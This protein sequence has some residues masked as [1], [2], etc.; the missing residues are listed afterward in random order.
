MELHRINEKHAKYETVKNNT[1]T[2]NSADVSLE[3]CEV[4]NV[5]KAEVKTT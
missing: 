1:D 3:K 4:S 2:K 5:K